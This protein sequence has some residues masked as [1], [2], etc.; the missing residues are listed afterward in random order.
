[1]ESATSSDAGSEGSTAN[2]S[3][4][5][6]HTRRMLSLARHLGVLDRL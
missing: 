1:M 6:E 5:P 2:D 3:H 4:K